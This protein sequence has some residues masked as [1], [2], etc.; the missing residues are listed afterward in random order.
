MVGPT[1]AGTPRGPGASSAS[2]GATGPA[3]CAVD[4]G[5]TS[6]SNSRNS[7]NSC[8]G[9]ASFKSVL[10][11]EASISD[12]V[13]RITQEVL[14]P[15]L[16]PS[17][18][19]SP[20]SPFTF[21]HLDQLQQMLQQRCSSSSS[22]STGTPGRRAAG[23]VAAATAACRGSGT[24]AAAGGSTAGGSV[25]GGGTPLGS[26]SELGGAV[27]N[28][29][30]PSA[31]PPRCIDSR[32]L[33][34]LVP[35]DGR[36]LGQEALAGLA[37]AVAAALNTV[38]LMTPEERLKCRLL[39]PDRCYET[40][41]REWRD[42]LLRKQP[43]GASLSCVFGRGML[44]SLLLCC[45]SS[46]LRDIMGGPLGFCCAAVFHRLCD[47]ASL[48]L[49]ARQAALQSL[50]TQDPRLESLLV[51][52][53]GLGFLSRDFGSAREE[54]SGL[55]SFACLTNDRQPLHS[56]ALVAAK[57]IFSR[58]L[59]KMPR[60]YIVR[61]V[62]DRN[63][64][65]FCLIKQ[66]QIIGGC[67]FRPYFKQKFAEVAF[68]AVTS[69][70]QVKG[71]GT[72]LMNH[73]KEHVKK[74]GIEY[75][76]TYADNFAVGYFR[77]QGFTQKISMPKERWFGFIKDY[78]GGTLMECRISP[79]VDYLRL[80]AIL[81]DQQEAVQRAILRLKPPRVFPGLTCWQEDPTR[82]LHPSEVPGVLEYGWT[83][84][85]TA[86]AAG[87]GAAATRP[88]H[89]Q[90]V[91]VL[92]VLA[93]HH[94]AWPFQRPVSTDEA[95]DY[96]EIIAQPTDISTMKKKAKKK[97][98]PNKAAFLSELSR[99]FANCRRYNAPS[100]IYYKYANELEKFI[101]PKALQIQDTQEPASATD[102]S[103]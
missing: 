24:A 102:A 74:S 67:C 8:N 6:S 48:S 23:G 56:M 49:P 86:D 91:Q 50:T 70:E 2:S 19:P 61:L 44:R 68:L 87:E 27:E 57:N 59:P 12:I 81:N 18:Q 32:S 42:F 90:I 80:F 14:Q 64:Y 75:F 95:P 51:S 3:P 79:K 63:H 100:T 31:Q 9:L 72:R 53:S 28:L 30:F 97:Q 66:Q 4:A 69:A 39:P 34:A 92:D 71:Y 29:S 84:Q 78:E 46:L 76:L 55:I 7:S 26:R 1:A 83:P 65:T 33:L 36:L 17:Q 101:W 73:L 94:S 43:T 93:C 82:V 88:L 11:L 35:H 20:P 89:E 10:P 16:V 37:M 54:Q 103:R 45:C 85:A 58:Q 15:I 77:K 5:V 98:F 62:F 52:E 99:M 60:E 22:S 21:T 13:H 38:Q 41:Y 25:P 96:Y 40:N 47:E